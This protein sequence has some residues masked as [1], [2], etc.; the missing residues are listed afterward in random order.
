[1]KPIRR[2]VTAAALTTA[3]AAGAVGPA[4]AAAFSAPLPGDAP[5][6]AAACGA[7]SATMNQTV[8]QLSH[9][10]PVTNVKQVTGQLDTLRSSLTILIHD[11]CV[12]SAP[13]TTAKADTPAV[14]DVSKCLSPLFDLLGNVVSLIG[15]ALAV[16]PN[17]AAL[18][19]G[20]TAILGTVTKILTCV[21]GG[22]LGGVTGSLPVVGGATG[23]SSGGSPLSGVTGSLP[24]AGGLTGAL[25]VGSASP[26]K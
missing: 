15:D 26:T 20:L 14:P 6:P 16:P 23:G 5:P 17:V 7:A 18:T 19:S 9:E 1:M 24:V 10:L 13:L 25:P 12:R 22:A 8:A 4:A 21:P 11:G 3:L 2:L